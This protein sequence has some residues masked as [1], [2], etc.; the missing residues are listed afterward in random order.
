MEA[1]R[2][3]HKDRIEAALVLLERVL[4]G[5]VTSRPS[6]VLELQT[7]Y[8]ERGIEPFRGLSKEGVYDKEIATVYLVGIYGAGVLAPGD[9]DNVFYIE[10]RALEAVEIIRN[11]GEVLTPELKEALVKKTGE[12]KGKSAEDRVFRVLRLVFTGVMLGYY[13]EM[14]LVKSI[15][16]YETAYPELAQR[17]LNYAAFY[18]AYKIAEEI[19][20]GKIRSAEGLKIAKYTYCLRLGF[21]KCKPGDKLIAEVAQAVYKVDRSLLARLFAKGVLPK[22]G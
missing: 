19:A 1:T 21:Q 15:K 14:L 11:T 16:T 13:P 7:V 3:L 4:N 20:L 6:L 2:Q 22:I 12:V 8:K 10:N 5:A 18:S 9:F 17:L